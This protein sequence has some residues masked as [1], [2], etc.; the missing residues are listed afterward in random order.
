MPFDT[1]AMAQAVVAE[2]SSD[3]ISWRERAGIRKGSIRLDIPTRD[4]GEMLH[5]M[6][7]ICTELPNVCLRM[8][9]ETTEDARIEIG[10][11][12]LRMLGMKV[13]RRRPR[14]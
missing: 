4:S 1:K 2:A 12:G 14:R 13:A 5:I 8:E 7:Y 3:T 10:Q 6:R 11:S 9:R